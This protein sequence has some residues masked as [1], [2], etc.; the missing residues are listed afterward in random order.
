MIQLLIAGLS[1]P[2]KEYLSEFS[3]NELLAI[4]ITGAFIVFGCPGKQCLGHGICA[5]NPN[6]VH[7]SALSNTCPS[8]EASFLKTVDGQ[9]ALLVSRENMPQAVLN[10]H[11]SKPYFQIEEATT[12]PDF[13]TEGLEIPEK[14]TIPS[15][16]YELQPLNSS[17][18]IWLNK[19]SFLHL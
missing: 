4:K 15:G 11:F 16:L 19:S 2:K 12:L 18:L 5:I 1:A 10:A 9:I 14:Y 13:I 6:G 7:N 8:I 3:S 17:I